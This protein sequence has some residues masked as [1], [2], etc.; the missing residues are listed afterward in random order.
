M[1][2]NFIKQLL[3]RHFRD[4]RIYSYARRAML[5]GQYALRIPDEIDFTAF[6]A[7]SGH[8][9]GLVIDIGAN[10][11]QSAIA[12]SFILPRFQILSFEP[13]P[14]LWLDLDFVGR[15]I[16]PRFAYKKLGLGAK[17]ESMTLFVPQIGN[18]PITTRASLSRESA[19]AHCD[20]LEKELGRALEIR[21]I[22]V[23]I[24]TFDSLGLEPDI[25]KIDVE[26][27]EIHV[28]KGM[29]NTIENC[30]P[31]LM[32]ESNPND[33]KCMELLVGHGYQIMHFDT[34]HKVLSRTSLNKT[35]NWFALPEKYR[36]YFL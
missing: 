22:T 13:N 27:Y 11:G 6:R 20:N 33:D 3:R 36:N 21:E 25:V 16:G 32:L 9:K 5:L 18:F 2:Y 28:L 1:N 4:P 35:R 8:D 10:G 29:I 23:H 31:I 26:G 19:K 30:K 34:K 7:L 24:V 15:V 14:A 17:S 12:L